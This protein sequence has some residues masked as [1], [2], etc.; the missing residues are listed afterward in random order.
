[1]SICSLPSPAPSSI[2]RR[3]FD[4]AGFVAEA[5][6]RLRQLRDE[7]GVRSFVDP[8]PIEL[9]RDAGTDAGNFRE[10]RNE[11]GLHDWLLLRGNGPA[12]ILARPHGRGNR[13]TLH[14]RDHPADR[15]D[16]REG[17]RDQGCDRRAGITALEHKFLEAACIAQKAT[18][19]PIITHTQDGVARSGAAGSVRRGRRAG[20]SLPDRSLLRQCRS[21]VSPARGGWRIVYRL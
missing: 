5:V 20:A 16:R 7:H 19:V 4:R 2:R 15:N 3:S 12:D 9:G 8:C 1:M 11:C 14:P 18:G 17:G 13:R 6:Q 10:V 21:G